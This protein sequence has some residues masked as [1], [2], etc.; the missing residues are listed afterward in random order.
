MKRV[1]HDRHQAGQM[2]AGQLEEYAYASDVVVLG[3]PRGGV[4]VAYA[5]AERLKVALDIFLVRKLGIPGNEELAMGAIAGDGV[6]VL[7]PEIIAS[8]NIPAEA[9]ELAARREMEELRRRERSYRPAGAHA[10][11]LHGRRVILVDD[12]LATGATM[13]AAVR[14]ARHENPAKL[15]VAVPVA[16]AGSGTELRAEADDFVCLYTPEWFGAVSQF[17]DDFSQLEDEE[18]RYCLAQAENWHFQNKRSSM[19]KKENPHAASLHRHE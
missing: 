3:L 6:C 19:E 16:P 2:L 9:I 11:D 4:P 8:L 18:V 17:Y 13:L 5:I 7:R 10:L 14:A 1:F 15:I 12:G